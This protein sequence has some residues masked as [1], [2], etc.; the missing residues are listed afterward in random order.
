[1]KPESGLIKNPFLQPL[2]IRHSLFIQKG[3][4]PVLPV[5]AVFNHAVY[6]DFHELFWCGFDLEI[7]FFFAE[8][9]LK[10]KTGCSTFRVR[11]DSMSLFG[12]VEL[13][14]GLVGVGCTGKTAT[15]IFSLTAL[16]TYYFIFKF[17]LG[18]RVCLIYSLNNEIM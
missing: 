11:H 17:I 2:T 5:R 18:I 4:K 13:W 6:R 12:F 9:A 3:F 7:S 1:M 8:T 15:L 16:I 10:K 14:P